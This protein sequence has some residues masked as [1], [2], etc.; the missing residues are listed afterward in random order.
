MPLPAKPM[1]DSDELASPSNNLWVGNL[2]PDVTD[3]DLMELFAKY[4]ALDSVTTYSARSYAFI[5]FKR[6]EDA[7]A[8]KNALQGTSLRGSSLKIEFARPAKACKQLWVGGISPAVTKEELEAEFRKIGKIED[9]KFYRDRNTACVEFFNLEDASQAM[10][11]MNG[12]RIGGEHIRVDFLRSHT[13]KRDQ[14]FDY[15]Q[16]QGK[17]L[18]P[19][20]AY[21]GQK[22]PLLSQAPMG[23]KGDAQPSNVLWIGYPPAVQIDEQMLHN[24][25]IL[26][27]E[28][29]RIK[30]FP[31]RNYSTVEF[32]SVDEARRAKEGLQ[33]RLFNDPR[34]TITYSSNDLV[35]GSDYPGF[36]A[37]SNGPRPDVLLNENPFQQLQ[38]DAFGHNR[39]MVPNNFTGQLPPSGIIG[40]NVR[41]QP[42]G[43]L[44]RVDSVIS[45]PEFN[46]ISAL[47]KL[48]DG[49]SK[50]NMA[51]NWKRPSPPAPGMLSSPAPVARHPTR[52]TTGAWDVLDI[53]HIPRDSKRSRIDGPLPVDEA[54]FPLR[55]I[56]DRGLALEQSYGI[57]PS[58]DGGGSGPFANIHGKNHLGPMSSRITA[59]VHGMVQ[60]DNDHIWRGI[61]AKGG[62]PVCRARCVPIGKGI[63]TE[64]P[65]VIDCSA[66]TGLDILTKH[67]ADAIG[68]DIVFFLPD[69]EDDFA[70][71]TEFLRY[72]SAKNRAGVAKFVDNTTLFLVPPSDFLTRVLKVSGPE[73]L[74]GV[75]LKFPQVPSSAP[76]QQ[77]SNLP[78]PTSQFMQQIPLS[79]TEYGLIPVK[80]EQVVSMDYNRQLREDSKL[81]SKPAYLSTGGPPSVHSVPPDYA[82]NN[83]I[84][85]SQAGVALTPE[86]IATLASF[87]PSTTPSS[88][89]DG[90]KPGVG[91]STMKPP[92]PPVAPNDG[93]QSY[94]WKQDSQSADQTTH[95]PQQMRSMYSVHNAHYQPYPPASAP[96]GNPAQVVSSSSHI[97]DTAATMHQQGAVSSR[98]MPNFMMPT[99]SGQVAA[100]PHGS[101]HYQPKVSPSNQK[102][103]GVV[104]GTDA[105][106]L[107]NSQ[108]FQQPN[109]N[110]LSFQQP[111]NSIALTSQVSGANSS[112]QQTAMPYTVDQVN[113]GTP[114][115]QLS[116][117]GVSQ[118]T[119]EV[120][121]DKNQRYQ[122]TLQFAANLLLQIQ[123]KQQQAAGGHG[124]GIQQ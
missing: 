122:S 103:F 72:L 77:A 46:E 88:A 89:I 2:A 6:V 28:I 74:Y 26:F 16:L 30:S 109:N 62:T 117:S 67:Y 66:R 83:A 106:V 21:S 5:Y 73:R 95:P 34:I 11:I 108:A 84:A 18:G 121:A 86:L 80:E 3:A 68:F 123:Q 56:D 39:P 20:D 10:K 36:F 29:E 9:F 57:D 75:F 60:P 42:F 35:H 79:Q 37:G 51:P 81:P 44:S 50:S 24:A 58:I 22:R 55:N 82:P 61:I 40:P 43:P 52:S 119:P 12:K 47:H 114:N 15:G 90:T 19:S 14:L 112:Q 63:G 93:S 69:S 104:Q 102:V 8:A 70:S 120:E 91:S 25:M 99:Q 101:Q 4:G 94:L 49:S 124:P 1:R 76:M 31:L 41:L 100:S 111:N 98:N 33:G 92:F 110:P 27:G 17:S 54:P 71:Y 23:R 48:Q 38:M 45:G 85:G 87:L 32:R 115:Q 97:Q 105:P 116:V 13:I 118:G 53:N 59:G 7:K 113:S 78:V 107:Y 96:A 64:L 65:D